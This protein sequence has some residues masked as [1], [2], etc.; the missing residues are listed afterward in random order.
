MRFNGTQAECEELLAQINASLGYPRDYTQADIDNGTLARVGGG[1]HVP[2]SKLRTE[3]AA[4]VQIVDMDEDGN[5]TSPRRRVRFR[6]LTGD[7]RQPVGRA[8]VLRLLNRASRARLVVIEGINGERADA[9]I[10]HRLSGRM[11]SIGDAIE[12]GIGPGG[13][14]ALRAH[15]SLLLQDEDEDL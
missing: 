12:A 7:H 2:L 8:R 6:R 3:T 15:V 1:R 4:R 9:I 11:R 13:V 5:A 14:Q 10:A